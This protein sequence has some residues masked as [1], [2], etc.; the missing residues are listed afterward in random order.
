MADKDL[1]RLGIPSEG[2]YLS[3]YCERTGRSGVDPAAWRFYMAFNLFRLAGILQGVLKRAIDGN[4]ADDNARQTGQRARIIAEA[5]RRVVD[6][7]LRG[8]PS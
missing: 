6:S 2:E 7:E 5:G 4:A 8:I 1:P 3:Q